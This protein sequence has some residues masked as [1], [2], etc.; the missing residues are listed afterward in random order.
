[1]SS[2]KNIKT[3]YWPQIFWTVMYFQ[4][5]K[6]NEGNDLILFM[7]VDWIVSTAWKQIWRLHVCMY[8]CKYVY[9]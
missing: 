3:S 7:G 5:E 6:I 4:D 1:M 9:I 8:V 2:V